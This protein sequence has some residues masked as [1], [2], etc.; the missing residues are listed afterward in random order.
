MATLVLRVQSAP[1]LLSLPSYEA[2]QVSVP[3]LDAAPPDN[4]E[5]PTR[6]VTP[7]P[8][9]MEFV[10]PAILLL[11]IVSVPPL[12]VRT[13]Q[14]LPPLALKVLATILGEEL[15]LFTPTL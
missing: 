14:L 11:S 8:L 7:V 10:L 2:V 1:S 3:A 6:V 9:L 15:L 13:P 5:A 12:A 4:W